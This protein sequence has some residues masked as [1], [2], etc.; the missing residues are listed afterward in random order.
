LSTDQS[1]DNRPSETAL[2]TAFLRALA[3]HDL[4]SDAQGADTLAELFLPEEQKK[5]LHDLTARAWVL[6]NHVSPG[7]YEFMFAR[8]AFF[9]EVVGQ[10]LQQNTRQLVFL[11]AGYDS[12]P[13]RFAHLIR[14]TIIFELDRQP[15]QQRKQ[16]CL[17]QSG[18][19]IPDQVRFVPIDFNTDCLQE[20]MAGA[21]FDS[22]KRTLFIWEGV[23]YYLGA[24][25]VDN[26]LLFVARNS[27]LGSSI[28]FDYASI[29]R[30]TLDEPSGM[31]LR[32]HM[33]SR[34]ANEPARFGIPAGG[35]ASFLSD[36]GFDVLEHLT[37][38]E[39]SHKYM[40]IDGPGS[41]RVPRM[42]CLVH[43]ILKK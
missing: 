32:E 7:A 14:D 38:D 16:E 20:K 39:M 43:A 41:G 28:C 18:I 31:G 26:M 25:A 6:Q 24:Q 4:R 21:G 40:H 23:T 19:A 30:E 3:A 9:D 22:R 8:T 15:T 5:P 10:A 42:F 27:P 29:S 12:R 13:Y 35:I 33:R 37:A 34:Y 1:I 17:Q 36:R 2:A 11:G